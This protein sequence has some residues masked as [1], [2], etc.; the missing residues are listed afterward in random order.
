MNKW[1]RFFSLIIFLCYWPSLSINAMV[2]SFESLPELIEKNPELQSLKAQ[3]KEL[4]QR[5]SRFGLSFVPEVELSAGLESF[6]KP[7][8]VQDTQP[9]YAV[10]ASL[11]IY[12]GGV[13]LLNEKKQKL[14]Y[15]QYQAHIKSLQKKITT[16]S[17]KSLAYFLY[18]KESQD[19]LRKMKSRVQKQVERN[20][21]NVRLGQDTGTD[22]LH[23]EIKL[24]EIDLR[25]SELEL[26]K[27]RHLQE[28]LR[29]LPKQD[30]ASYETP[31]VLEHDHKWDQSYN[32]ENLDEEV[33]ILESKLSSQEKS[34]DWQVSQ[35]QGLP[36]VD[37]YAQ[38][39]QETQLHEEEF[40]DPQQRSHKVIGLQLKLP[41]ASFFKKADEVQTKRSQMTRQRAV[42]KFHEQ[43]VQD[44]LHSEFMRLKNL[45]NKL[46][47]YEKMSKTAEVYAK[48]AEEEYERGV[49][50][51]SDV[52]NAYEQMA[53]M[54]MKFKNNQ[55]QFMSL[56]A[57]LFI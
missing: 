16:A 55:A 6:D 45:H 56:L 11:N 10:K 54:K 22:L 3:S 13:D 53:Q 21:R 28:L 32:L 20:Q 2:V 17:Y 4:E 24:Q 1:H 31:S 41:I 39:A 30:P 26:K 12:R 43:K 9:H 5:P 47:Q 18:S 46:H 42:A 50:S 38:W 52:I 49:K 40:E 33:Y 29:Y 19:I 34:L 51:S 44:H 48:K 23:F 8:V 27:N 37:F 15:K 35:K 14:E 57:E 25:L 36:K 7:K